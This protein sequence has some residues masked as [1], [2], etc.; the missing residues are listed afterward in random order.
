MFRVFKAKKLSNKQILMLKLNLE[1]QMV[2]VIEFIENLF[3]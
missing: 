2:I 1:V 3:N